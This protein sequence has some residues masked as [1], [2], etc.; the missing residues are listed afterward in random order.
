MQEK[1]IKLIIKVAEIAIGIAILIKDIFNGGDKNDN[2][3]ASK[4]K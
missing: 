2:G 3:G 1:T 4:K